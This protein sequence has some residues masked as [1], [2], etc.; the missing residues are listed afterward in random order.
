M[1]FVFVFGGFSIVVFG[2]VL[3]FFGFFFLVFCLLRA[4]PAAYGSSQARGRI[5][6]PQQCCILNPLS[7]A[8]D[9]NN[10]LVD[11]SEVHYL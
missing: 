3:F 11:T 8:R 9:R 7:E 6:Q 5:P 1:F 2:F 4:T 10:A